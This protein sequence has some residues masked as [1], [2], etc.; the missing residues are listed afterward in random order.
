M[1]TLVKMS[2]IIEFPNTFS[3]INGFHC[4]NK[5][6]SEKTCDTTNNGL[7]DRNTISYLVA[8]TAKKLNTYEKYDRME[9]ILLFTPITNT[10]LK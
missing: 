8:W 10:I 9:L 4:Y 5:I 2:Q 1:K 3:I 7:F 6:I